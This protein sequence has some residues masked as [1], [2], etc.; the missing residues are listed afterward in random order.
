MNLNIDRNS[1]L[2][3]YVQLY[4]R[5][6][7]D[8]VKGIYGY[9][10]KLP[11]KR[12]MATE[13]GIS[14]ITIEHAYALLCDE[15]YIESR[16]RS[17]FFV[18][19][20]SDDGFASSPKESVSHIAHHN[21]RNS[22]F[23]F[24]F[25]VL[26]KTMRRV[27]NDYGETILEKSPNYGCTE[28]REALR[29]YLARN[30]SIYVETEQI[31]IGSGA[32]YLYS[33]IV[34]ILGRERIYALESPSYEKIEQVYRTA[35]VNCDLLPLGSDGIDSFAL[36]KTKATVLHISPYRSFP[37]GITAS[38]SK[39][40]EY[41][42]WAKAADRFI[43]EDDFESEFTLASKPEETL[44][45]LSEDRNV[46]Y[47]NTFSKTISPSL[48]VGYMVLPKHLI[49]RFSDALGFFSCTVPTFEQ[50]VLAELISGGDF[51][52]HIN[53]VRRAKRKKLTSE[54]L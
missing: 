50:F 9:G 48:R 8:I 29:Q 53:R 36:N 51:E 49:S 52:R 12:L 15:G 14:T 46:I 19:F 27:L 25:S 5:L 23:E 44:F 47:L 22:A 33:L 6:K 32:E 30:R 43:V 2:P 45:A 28:L 1:K 18:I 35:G 20:R 17:G 21:S 24:P 38:A 54:S 37:T 3:A 11:S 13:T 31:I 42:R 34:G 10:S 7:E 4:N 40:Y 16:E 26:T 41:I 39:R